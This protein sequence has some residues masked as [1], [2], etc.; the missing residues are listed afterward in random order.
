MKLEK[1]FTADEINFI[2]QYSQQNNIRDEEAVIALA[3]EMISTYSL[4]FVNGQTVL[5]ML[6]LLAVKMPSWL[7]LQLG[8]LKQSYFNIRSTAQS[9]KSLEKPSLFEELMMLLRDKNLADQFNNFLG[10]LFSTVQSFAGKSSQK[11]E[12]DENNQENNDEK[13]DELL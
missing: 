1:Y 4:K 2:K 11:G 8:M 7:N 12:E 13:T 9:I 5:T 10:N 3:R 6:D